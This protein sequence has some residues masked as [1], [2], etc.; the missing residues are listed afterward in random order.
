MM[1]VETK[2]CGWSW[3]ALESPVPILLLPT[4]QGLL[5][6]A[7][8]PLACPCLQRPSQSILFNPQFNALLPGK[9]FLFVL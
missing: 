6:N 9:Q 3:M 7:L 1:P 2:K 4:R 8:S 5:S